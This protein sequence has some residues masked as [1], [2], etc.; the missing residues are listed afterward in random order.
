MWQGRGV[1]EASVGDAFDTWPVIDVVIP[2]LNEEKS[3]P[4]V[5]ADMPWRAVRR[6]VVADNGSDDDTA[7]V[8]REAGA[9][10]V[11]QDERGYG[12]ACLAALAELK[13]DPPQIVVFMDGDYSDHPE[14]LEKVVEPVVA[15]DVDL[16]IGSRILGDSE[17]GSLLPQAI[18]GNWLSCQLMDLAFGYRFSDLGPFR[19][20]TWEALEELEM[21]DRNFGWT[22]EMQARAAKYGMKCVEVPV[23]YRRRVG[24]SKVTGTLKGSVMAGIKILSTIGWE[25]LADIR[26]RFEDS[27]VSHR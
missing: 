14:E 9:T 13:D 5:L 3:L 26:G 16:V 10:V 20:V 22:V 18:F 6:V 11:R 2:A 8:A 4:L 17:A 7:K 12:A 24:K 23:S 27:E 15:E 21:R 1:V 19:A 25:A